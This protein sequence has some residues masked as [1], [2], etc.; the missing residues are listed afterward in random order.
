MIINRVLCKIFTFT[1]LLVCLQ[2]HASELSRGTLLGVLPEQPSNGQSIGLQ[3][4]LANSTASSLG[5]KAGDRILKI[6]NQTL[7]NF[8]ELIAVV[9][10]LK[11]KQPI[12]V[13]FERN[14][15]TM[16]R[17]GSMQPRPYEV[18]DNAEVL[19]GSVDYEG[20]QLRAIT[21]KPNGVQGKAPAIFFIQGYTCGSIDMGMIPEATTKQLVEQ[22][23]AA[24]YVVFRVEKPGVG[25]SQSKQHCN[26]LNFS[27][28]AKAFTHA[29]KALKQQP[30]VNSEQ[31]YLWGHSLGVLHSA[32]VANRE[33]V[34]GIIGYGGVLK[35]WYDYMLDI[36]QHQS[37]KHFN[38]PKTR[39]KRNKALM[40]P[41]LDMWLNSNKDWQEITQHPATKAAIDADLIDINGERIIDRH[42]S[43]FRDLNRYDFSHL[44]RSLDVPV[45]MM[46]G[47]L[48][49]QAIEKDWAFDLVSLSSNSQSKALEIEGAEHAFMRYDSKS[50]YADARSNR[51]FNP[52]QP[53][54]RF[55]TRI[56][57]QSLKWLEHLN[58][59]KPK[60]PQYS[61]VNHVRYTNGEPEKG[62]VGNGFLIKHKNKTYA[63]TVKHA[64]LEAK[65]DA[66]DSVSIRGH[67]D[68]WR[69]HPNRSPQQFVQLGKLLN[70]SKEEPLDMQILSRDWLIF[71]VK[72]NQSNLQI[73]SLRDTPLVQGEQLTAFGCSY[74][75]QTNCTQSQY[76]GTYVKSNAT[77]L[78]IAM[79]GLSMGKLRGL[80]G[81]PVLDEDNRLVGIVSN[82]VRKEDGEGF[83]F[84]PA[85]LNYLKS[86][87][88]RL[89]G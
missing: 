10:P 18:S 76:R 64:L 82:V 81:S 25:D 70:E 22:F 40:A 83:D 58:T 63:V 47:S 42:Y 84:A 8:S 78:R 32:V 28:E 41:V 87:L 30:F 56:G 59:N 20:N 11:A 38:T 45:L 2:T 12:S 9:Q 80:S 21:Y 69:I 17:K 26:D 24:G 62:F 31:V 15:K 60:T 39:A 6:N 74:S 54:N 33:S 57:E 13:T 68:D 75:E 49:I 3:R 44:W 71:E 61:G 88:A 48:D 55:D 37:V 79:P 5:L 36:Y 7:A 34:A 51:T 29:L 27:N 77:N 35:P 89:N 72:E 4:V 86:E 67:I 85:N 19:Y 66:M 50:Q 52:A 73:L 43:F 1:L 65:T 46:H 16:T 23:A 53:G 14:G